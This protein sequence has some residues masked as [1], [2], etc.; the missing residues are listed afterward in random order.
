MNTENK[1]ENPWNSV[2]NKV[3]VITGAANGIGS[4]VAQRFAEA[5]AHVAVV[6]KDERSAAQVVDQIL[7]RGGKAQSYF[8][9]V[10]SIESVNETSERIRGEFGP[11]DILINNA[12]ITRR[13]PIRDAT[14][15]DWMTVMDVNV[16][17]SYYWLQ[18]AMQ[19]MM[20]KKSGSII[21]TSSPAGIRGS[22]HQI[23]YATSKAA[24]LGM[25]RSAARE[26]GEW[27]VTV[28]A[29]APGAKTAMTDILQTDADLQK[30]FLA[31]KVLKRFA[32]PDEIAGTYLFLASDQARYM[33]GQVLAVD[34]GRIMVR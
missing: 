27:N 14:L 21:F 4:A 19:D 2:E 20:E 18:A 34:G 24:I 6:D 25:M 29:V 15:A 10:T 28:N 23:A 13:A 26:L 32:E 31:E 17:G 1:I 33:T 22:V 16:H 3:T 7:R 5:G 9:D 11:I 12:G 8:S 30:R